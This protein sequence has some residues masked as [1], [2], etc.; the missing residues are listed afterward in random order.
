M[1]HHCCC[2]SDTSGSNVIPSI[3]A[4]FSKQSETIND[5]CDTFTREWLHRD[6]FTNSNGSVTGKVIGN[7]DYESTKSEN[8]SSA[9]ELTDTNRISNNWSHSSNGEKCIDCSRIDGSSISSCC[10]LCCRECF[11]DQQQLHSQN[12]N[13]ST[14]DSN[15]LDSQEEDFTDLIEHEIIEM[16]GDDSFGRKV[17][18]IY[19]CRLPERDKLD[20]NRLLRYILHTLDQFVE[21]DY[22]LVYFHHGL[23]S[24]NKPPVKWLWS[25]LKAFDR[26]YKKNLKN[27]YL[28]HPTNF[29]RILWQLFKPAIR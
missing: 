28:V 16:V 13:I 18:T 26:R 14:D 20:H 29:I 19:A 9:G 10:S 15:T 21:T 5:S 24:A 11:R 3:S 4:T 17:I 27:L 1:N 8:I 2:P 12:V 6:H 25:A 7:G 22:V 23:D